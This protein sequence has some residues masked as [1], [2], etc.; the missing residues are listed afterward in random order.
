[1]T[2][3]LRMHNN[4]VVRYSISPMLEMRKIAAKE[5]RNLFAEGIPVEGVEI[6]VTF[7]PFYVKVKFMG[8]IVDLMVFY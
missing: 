6:T 3:V 2:H 8:R 5:E 1:M 7:L 4:T